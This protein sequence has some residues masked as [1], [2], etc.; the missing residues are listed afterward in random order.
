MKGFFTHA[1]SLPDQECALCGSRSP[2]IASH[3]RVCG[4]C[5]RQRPHEAK[6]LLEAAHRKVREDFGMATHAPQTKGGVHC[7]L[8]VRHCVMGEGEIGYCG[9]RIAR[10]GRLV[11]LAGT[12]RRG[13]LQWY[14]DPL[15]TNCVAMPFCAGQNRSGYHN[16]A[17]F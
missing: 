11:H 15:P 14:R 7:P 2:L 13:L 8:C 16:L 3:L 4:R 10:N 1:E 5:I 9:L 17:V 6:P 12:P